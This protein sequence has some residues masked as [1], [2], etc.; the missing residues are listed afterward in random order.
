MFLLSPFLTILQIFVVTSFETNHKKETGYF[1][2]IYESSLLHKFIR[3][4]IL[5]FQYISLPVFTSVAIKLVSGNKG[6]EDDGCIILGTLI[7]ILVP[8]IYLIG[9]YH[10]LE[11]IDKN[12]RL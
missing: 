11:I 10:L 7:L 3:V 6:F 12:D 9:E 2:K 5:T 1:R 8:I 4:F